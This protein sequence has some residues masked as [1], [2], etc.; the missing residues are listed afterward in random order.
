MKDGGEQLRS[1]YTQINS[2]RQV[3]SLVVNGVTLTQSLPIIEYLEET[4]PDKPLLP[5]DPILRAHARRIAEIV[6]SGIQPLQNMDTLK[7]V[8]EITDEATKT[9][10]AQHFITK[11][12][13]GLEKLL[14][15]TSGRFCVGDQ[16]TIADLSLF[17]Q[18]LNAFRYHVDLTPYPVI[19]RIYNECGQL[20]AFQ[21]AHPS[22]QPDC[23][24]DV[25][26]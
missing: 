13:D 15:E 23:P 8:S 9:K 18:V 20:E 4:F 1:D 5:K 16:V 19:H 17:P 24:P 10:W 12:F 22:Q 3:P 26:F 11:G 14:K 25:K 7:K 6:N 2:M 21:K